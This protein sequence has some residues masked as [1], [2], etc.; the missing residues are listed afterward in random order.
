M[1]CIKILE[2]YF[3]GIL[4]EK[5]FVQ[6]Y[7]QLTIPAAPGVLEYLVRSNSSSQCVDQYFVV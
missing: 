4:C 7:Q 5:M 2:L 3:A 1:M 6:F